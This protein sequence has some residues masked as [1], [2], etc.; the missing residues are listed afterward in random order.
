ML[1]RSPRSLGLPLLALLTWSTA[2]AAQ[3]AVDYRQDRAT[4]FLFVEAQKL[5]ERGDWKGA[6]GIYQGLLDRES[7]PDLMLRMATGQLVGVREKARRELAGLPAEFKSL[8]EELYGADA[9]RALAKAREA[10]DAGAVLEAVRR[11][12]IAPGAAEAEAQALAALLPPP[13]REDAPG[14]GVPPA[15]GVGA[16]P[17]RASAG[18]AWTYVSPDAAAGGENPLP[19]SAIVPVAAG[20]LLLLHLGAELV[21]VH[22][23]SGET[24]WSARPTRAAI[25]DP[26]A[27][28]FGGP[29]PPFRVPA[30]AHGSAAAV[31]DVHP[32]DGDARTVQHLLL[33]SLRD[34]LTRWGTRVSV[35]AQR[36]QA[37]EAMIY[38]PPLLAGTRL[39]V[40]VLLRPSGAGAHVPGLACLETAKGRVLWVTPLPYRRSAEATG[41]GGSPLIQSTAL[42]RGAG[43]IYVPTNRRTLAA[44]DAVTGEALWCQDYGA[45]PTV[46]PGS[47]AVTDVLGTNP[48]LVAD[49]AV[50]TAPC[51]SPYVLAYPEDGG[52]LRWKAGRAFSPHLLG[53]RDGLVFLAGNLAQALDLGTGLI[54]WQHRVFA[55]EPGPRGCLAGSEVL[56]C[57]LD[58]FLRLSA[59]T[60]EP[61]SGGAAGA[62][63]E[64]GT[65]KAFA[66]RGGLG[67][68]NLYVSGELLLVASGDRVLAF[69]N[70]TATGP[71]KSG[72]ETTG[73]DLGECVAKLGSR[74]WSERQAATERLTGMGSAAVAALEAARADEDPEIAWRAA[75]ILE[76]IHASELLEG[77]K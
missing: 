32:I 64:T 55:G 68:G 2:V 75:R 6:L 8:Y 50:V 10:K 71:R 46:P 74:R 39:Y 37:A 62:G 61:S 5:R 53:S 34:G 76:R 72:G 20:P 58:G 1:R 31:L 11:Y 15:A 38:S 12:P 52:K 4:N 35:V 30:C 70:A 57:R 28:D 9:A 56:A 67:F 59:A 49:G 29:V 14:F 27:K 51:D 54:R 16:E 19:G 69:R 41:L 43:R 36:A 44:V 17:F 65:P 73:G 60:G 22:R 26:G 23:A 42:G 7:P 21:A 48:V 63:A 13:D 33:V 18:L 25:G 45:L 77:E 40:A 66:W 3:D 24:Q 47:P